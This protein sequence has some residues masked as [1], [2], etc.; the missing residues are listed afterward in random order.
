MRAAQRRAVVETDVTGAGETH[1]GGHSLHQFVQVE[2]LPGGVA[3]ADHRNRQHLAGL[4]LAPLRKA[5][6]SIVYRDGRSGDWLRG[7][8]WHH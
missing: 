2:I 8:Y 7:V 3:V 1:L 6:A 5:L 4:A